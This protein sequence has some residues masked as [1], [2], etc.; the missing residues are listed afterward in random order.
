MRRLDMVAAVSQKRPVPDF[1]TGSVTR[2]LRVAALLC[3][4]A[5]TAY[6]LWRYPSLPDV[7]PTHFNFAGEADDFGSKSSALWLA[8]VMTAMGAL[9]A[10]LSTR[11]NVLN[12]PGEITEINVQRMYREAERMMVWLLAG[13][14]VIYLGIVLSTVGGAG[15]AVLVAGLIIVLGSTLGGLVRLVIA[16]SPK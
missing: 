4:V 10:W 8:G 3:I 15:T 2:G 1:V 9:I 6:V 16:D 14:A 13:L 7:V 11:P 12:Y 5:L